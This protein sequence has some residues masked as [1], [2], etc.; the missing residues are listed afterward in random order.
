MNWI[1]YIIWCVL[2][3]IGII[4]FPSFWGIIEHFTL[5]IIGYYLFE[6]EGIR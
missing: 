6:G 2:W 4:L 3:S 1:T 5:L